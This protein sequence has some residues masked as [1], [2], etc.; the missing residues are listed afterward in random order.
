LVDGGVTAVAVHLARIDKASLPA[1][2]RSVVLRNAS[3]RRLRPARAIS[4]EPTARRRP[5]CEGFGTTE[6]APVDFSWPAAAA[7]PGSFGR[8]LPG[9]EITVADKNGNPAATVEGEMMVSSP[10]TMIGYWNDRAATEAALRDGWYHSGDL[11]RRDPEGYLWFVGRKKEIIVHGGA[12]V[13]PT[14]VE[15]ALHQHAGVRDAAVVGAPDVAWGERVIAFVSPQALRDG[16][17]RR[18]LDYL[19]ERLHP[20]KLPDEIAFLDDLPKSVAGKVRRRTLCD[21]YLA[22]SPALTAAPLSGRT[23][24][25]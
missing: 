2:L 10:G 8:A 13:S 15:A 25:I 7:G 5:L 20:Y 18:T 19:A 4:G 12:N 23:R 11:I 21:A 24:E 16:R 17:R 22:W 9:I 14:E 6:T 1:S 3:Q